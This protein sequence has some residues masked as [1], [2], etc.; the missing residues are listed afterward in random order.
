VAVNRPG[1]RR[2]GT[3][4]RPL[5]DVQ[6]RLVDP[7]GRP[8]PTGEP[9]ELT[10][11]GPNVMKGYW[12]APVATAAALRDGWLRT[13]DVARIGPDGELRLVDR[14]KDVILRGG[15]SVYPCEVEEVLREHPAVADAAVVGVPDAELGQDVGAAVVP[16]AGTELDPDELLEWARERVA[17]YKR[18]R[19]V[20]LVDE[21]AR[22]PA[23]KLLRRAIPPPPE[24]IGERARHPR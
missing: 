17:A 4:G 18:P 3:L 14:I 10:V 23:G 19:L 7:A 5:A 16:V 8:V 21:L 12:R 11:R 24:V 9:G 1:R 2:P 6:V 15:Y 13:G 22:G 20:W